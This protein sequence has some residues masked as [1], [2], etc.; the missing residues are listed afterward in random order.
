MTSKKILGTL[1]GILHTT[2]LY[3]HFTTTGWIGRAFLAKKRPAWPPGKEIIP[4]LFEK[5]QNYSLY[6]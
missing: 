2:G 3:R 4:E 5:L 1:K 6:H